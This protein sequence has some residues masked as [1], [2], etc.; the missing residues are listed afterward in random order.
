MVDV[1]VVNAILNSVKNFQVY[2][3]DL[4]NYGLPVSGNPSQMKYPYNITDFI[5]IESI[6]QLLP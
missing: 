5:S 2:I 4:Q 1:N 3:R 6:I